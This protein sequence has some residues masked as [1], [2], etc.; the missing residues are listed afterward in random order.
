MCLKFSLYASGWQVADLY[1]KETE[2]AKINV[3]AKRRKT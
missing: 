3:K 2:V 1:R